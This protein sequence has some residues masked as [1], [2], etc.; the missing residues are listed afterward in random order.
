M[1]LTATSILAGVL[2]LA[3]V[4]VSSNE[5]ALEQKKGDSTSSKKADSTS[6]TKKE[7]PISIPK[8]AEIIPFSTELSG[9]MAALKKDLR[10]G[11]DVSALETQYAEID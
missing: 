8:L 9:R 6:G 10:A 3:L 11:P 7:V 4:L 1:R 5:L 2:S